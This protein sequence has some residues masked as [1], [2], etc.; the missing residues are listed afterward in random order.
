MSSINNEL[1]QGK[2]FL[3][4]ALHVTIL[5]T[6]LGSLFIFYISNI[7]STELNN[8]LI[9]I[10]DNYFNKNSDILT[11]YNKTIYNQ[12]NINNNTI[13]YNYYKKIYSQPDLTRTLVNQ[14]VIKNIINVNILLVIIT[15]LFTIT[16]LIT[17]N[18]N[19]TEIKQLLFENIILF[20]IVGIIEFLFF[21]KIALKYVP[22]P[23]SLLL[24][25]LITN[26]KN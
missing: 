8:H 4:I 7:A 1:L 20:L 14:Q 11:K 25:S 3:N 10:I 6:I 15:I 12:Y 13:D 23:P 21:T 24:N 16:L 2:Y 9:D 17:K 5:F 26:L 19:Y 18:I 22:A